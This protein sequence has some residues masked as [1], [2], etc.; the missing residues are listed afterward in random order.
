MAKDFY[1]DT[2]NGEVIVTGVLDSRNFKFLL[3]AIH[4]RAKAGF[5]DV[6]IDF[7]GLTR[8]GPTSMIAI[9]AIIDRYKREGYCFYCKL[10]EDDKLKK[11]FKNSNWAFFINSEEYS[12]SAYERAYTNTGKKF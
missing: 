1:I 12:Q 11:L 5:Q 2:N 6:D 10:P 4:S 3:G 7:S 9:C 8:C